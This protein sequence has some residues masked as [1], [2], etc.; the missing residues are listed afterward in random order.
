MQYIS[1]YLSPL[2]KLTLAS[3]GSCL[4]GIWFDKQKYFGSTLT[5][6]YEEMPLPIFTETNAWLDCYFRGKEPDF[7]PALHL[8]GTPFRLE[9]WNVL[10]EIPYGKTI[11]Y[12]KIA[13]KIARQKGLRSMSAQAIGNAVGHNPVSILIPCHRVIGCNGNLTGYA[14][15]I[16]RKMSLLTLEHADTEGLFL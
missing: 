12:K 13:E 16:D 4:T 3:N 14:G 15:G 5:D 2:G 7:T 1:T 8:T 9:V 10:K 6:E 11:T